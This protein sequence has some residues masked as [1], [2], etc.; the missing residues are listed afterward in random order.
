MRNIFFA[1]GEKDLLPL[2]QDMC[3]S[4]LVQITKDFLCA[5]FFPSLTLMEFKIIVLMPTQMISITP[6]QITDGFVERR[7]LRL[8]EKKERI[9][10]A[11]PN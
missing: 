2:E 10:K 3:N 9:R 7:K 5:V 1:R 6:W 8:N 4:F 11:Q